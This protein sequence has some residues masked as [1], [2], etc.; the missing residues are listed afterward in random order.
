M[1]DKKSLQN[2]LF[3]AATLF[4]VVCTLSMV[5]FA[6][7]YAKSSDNDNYRTF[8]VSAEGKAVGVP[9]VAE[10]SFTVFTEGNTDVSVIET[11]NSQ[12]N[13]AIVD[14][15]R[16]KKIDLKDIKTD[17]YS[18]QPRYTN[19]S[20]RN[21]V[22]PNPTIEGYTV[23]QTTSVKIR[24]FSLIG[25]VLSN[26]SALKVNNVSQLSFKVDDKAKLENEARE[27]AIK[28]AMQK[29]EDI[30]KSA[31]FNVGKLTNLSESFYPVYASNR[32]V[33]GAMMQ[34]ADFAMESMV[35]SDS[36]VSSEE[37]ELVEAPALTAE[38]NPGTEEIQ[39]NISL[40]YTID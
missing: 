38:V 17:E 5:S 19:V 39:A 10:F 11:E 4:L 24:N 6:S 26:V 30:A 12:K 1:V 25:D 37:S 14:Y 29:A 9:D 27:K 28:I 40:T 34:K 13:K 8:T 21:G 31:G 18:V 23:S 22:C 15:L 2:Y 33:G 35:M 7:S 32:G 20:C 16:S 3:A 36:S